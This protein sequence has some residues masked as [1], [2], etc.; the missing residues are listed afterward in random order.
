MKTT[1]SKSLFSFM[2]MLLL[3]ACKPQAA[4]PTAIRVANNTTAPTNTP[5]PSPTATSTPI[6]AE[7][8]GEMLEVDQIA[9]GEICNEVW[10]G[11]VYV[12]GDIL[13]EEGCRLTIEPGTQIYVAANQD[14]SNIFEWNLEAGVNT[15]NESIEGVHPGEPFWDQLNHIYILVLGELAAIG[16]PDSMILFSSASL[17]PSVFDWTGI[18]YEYGVISYAIVEYYRVMDMGDNTQITHSVLRFNGGCSVCVGEKS[19]VVVSGNKLYEAGHE[20]IDIHNSDVEIVGNDL[21]PNSTYPYP[22]GYNGL[23]IGNCIA[24]NLADGGEVRITDNVITG[25]EDYGIDFIDYPQVFPIIENNTF[26][27]NQVNI[28]SEVYIDPSLLN[29]YL[30]KNMAE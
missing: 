24:L 5:T 9:H 14:N 19:G 25:C 1:N 4:T 29:G 23:S 2:I 8:R 6:Y 22:Y 11:I 12:D 27:N 3:L 21:G 16:E 7:I 18:Q 30:E 28:G 17:E 26:G 13:V 15:S 20:L 10:S